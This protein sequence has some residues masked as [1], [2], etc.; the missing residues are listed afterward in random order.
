MDN[1]AISLLFENQRKHKWVLKNSTVKQRKEK[2]ILLKNNILTAKPLILEALYKDLQKP[3]VEAI[4]SDIFPV[5]K[6][7]DHCLA[8]LGQWMATK[9]VATPMHIM[10]TS[11]Y[12]LPEAKGNTLIIS[13]WNYPFNLTLVPLVSAIAA[14]NTAIIKPSEYTEHTSQIIDT[15]IKQ[16]FAPE[17][18]SVVLGDAKVSTSLLALPW[19]H[20]FFTGSTHVGK[21]VMHAAA[22]NLSSV[23]L[24]L[25][26]KS[27]CIVDATAN[28]AAAAKRIAYTKFLN[29]GQTCIAP[30]YVLVHESIKYAFTQELI[31]IIRK[32]YGQND[33]IEAS[34]S[35]PRIIT[36]EHTNRMG[37]LIEDAVTKGAK[38]LLGGN[39][40]S[41]SKYVSPTLLSNVDANMDVMREEIFGPILPIITFQNIDEVIFQLQQK[42]K[43]LAS[44]IFSSNSD[45]INKIKQNTSSGAV[46]INDAA[47]HFINGNLPFGGVNHSGMGK[48]HGKAGF[49]E[50]SNA[51]AVLKQYFSFGTADFIFPP[52][53][54]KVK[55]IVKIMLKW[56]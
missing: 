12:I 4:L 33:D 52:Y 37:N 40:N 56:L 55:S 44:Y 5:I 3:E 30:D 51:K 53:T 7:I 34:T 23:T 25:G 13:P 21:I 26:G 36:K 46:C 43:P 42:D 1:T 16:T 28:I 50:F 41:N 27:P 2:L 6:E 17:E 48:C 18:V 49:D 35:Y 11:S 45:N 32:F 22:E 10:G 20:I 47:V 19:D 39:V 38:V 24:E 8:N 31:A 9:R 15:I 54:A 29:C 14:G